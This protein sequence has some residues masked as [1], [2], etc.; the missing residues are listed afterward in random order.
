MGIKMIDENLLNA[1]SA[2]EKELFKVVKTN[3]RKNKIKYH[4]KRVVRSWLSEQEVAEYWYTVED[5]SFWKL[6]LNKVKSESFK[7]DNHQLLPLLN[8]VF[9]YQQFP[10]LHDYHFFRLTFPMLHLD[11][12]SW[13]LHQA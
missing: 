11:S 8:Y 7:K 4:N 10:M 5:K 1:L 9:V 13:L 6:I 2:K 12:V 3:D